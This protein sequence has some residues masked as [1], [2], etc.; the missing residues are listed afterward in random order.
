MTTW[1][2]Q[3]LAVIIMLWTVSTTTLLGLL[4]RCC[5]SF[6]VVQKQIITRPNTDILSSSSC[7][8]NKILS[9]R[10][11]AD[12]SDYIS[13][14]YNADE[15]YNDSPSSD[16][17]NN[18][19]NSNNGVEIWLDLRGTS[20]SPSSALEF[21]ALEGQQQKQTVPFTK[22]LVS[23]RSDNKNTLFQ[24][25][26]MPCNINVLVDD[27]ENNGIIL[28]SASSSSWGKVLP[29][30]SSV[31]SIPILPDPLPAM[32]IILQGKWIV[33]DTTKGWKRVE[34]EERLSF[35]LPLAELISSGA[36]T[37]VGVINGGCF[38]SSSRSSRSG[39]GGGIG[40]TCHTKNEVVKVA[41]WIQSIT[42][43]FHDD[44]D[45][46]DGGD[47]GG[48]GIGQMSLRTKTLDNGLI[49]PDDDDDDDDDVT[50]TTKIQGMQY[51][52]VVPYDVELLKTASMLLWNE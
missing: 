48:G 17:N 6:N 21:W 20:L 36:T 11:S 13:L 7:N 46:D 31:K 38:S 10:S 32:D 52:I 25:N 19:R 3:E 28:E 30:Q 37:T 47:D 18:N 40:L 29:L 49:I 42:K 26:K 16:N 4:P 33:L 41:M 22:C 1:K 45:D 9:A 34:E 50:T 2:K 39:G 35:L 8:N 44:D 51:A 5:L 15:E 23:S 14:Y 43:R 27:D 12:N 24:R